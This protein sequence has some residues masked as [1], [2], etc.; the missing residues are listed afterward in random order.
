MK[1]Y[2]SVL[3]AFGL[4]SGCAS[5]DE[6]VSAIFSDFLE[7]PSPSATESGQPFLSADSDGKIFMSWIEPG[8]QKRHAF[9]VTVFD[10]VKWGIPRTIAEGGDFFVNWAD[11][12]SVF[13]SHDGLLAA[14]WLESSGE[15]V[16]AY[17]VRIS[18]SADDGMTWSEPVTPHHDRT[19]TEHGFASFFNHP[20]GGT[21]IVWL[22]G[23]QANMTGVDK[24]GNAHA[25][26]WNMQLRTAMIQS[27]TELSD[28]YILD[29]R[30]CE[31]CPTA[32][33]ET[34]DGI[35]IAYR[36][37][38]DEEI[39]DIYL[40]RYANDAWS[41]PYPVH[42]D[43]WNIAGCPVNGPSLA[44]DGNRV[45]VAWYTAADNE[46]RV[47]VS[48]SRDGGRTFHTPYRV[49]EG[50]PLGRVAVEML[51]DRSVLVVWVEAN[52]ENAALLVRRVYPDGSVSPAEQIALI[53]DDRSSGYPR[54][55]RMYKSNAIMFAWV[56]TLEKQ[57]VRTALG[58]VND[59]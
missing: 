47:Y 9:R 34:A 51:H 32:A 40:V 16:Y 7:I 50:L 3:I 37:R 22:D 25:G 11:V 43:G 13:R 46:A 24:G 6:N 5:G 30:V 41:D 35:L 36:N 28:E 21:G 57:G 53:S 38:S 56:D 42:I 59:E 44:S 12:P 17:D 31:C 29:Y 14:H 1:F 58:V 15:S 23:R 49:D 8:D 48:F 52:E 18:L 19:Q 26:D 2:F 33:I 4:L 45:A 39:R 54:M 20:G 10:G 27:D 55:A